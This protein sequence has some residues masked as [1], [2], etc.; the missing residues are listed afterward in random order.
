MNK[1]NTV[2][3]YYLNKK[4]NTGHKQAAQNIKDLLDKLDK[5]AEVVPENNY[6]MLSGLIADL[7]GERLN[8]DES[9][10]IRIITNS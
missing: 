1:I 8:M 6:T 4:E 5:N 3:N 2:L 7:K 10:L 9:E